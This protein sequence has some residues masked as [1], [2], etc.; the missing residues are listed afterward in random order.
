[1][2]FKVLPAGRKVAWPEAWLKFKF[3]GIFS[4]LFWSMSLRVLYLMTVGWL[5]GIL[6]Y[7]MLVMF[8]NILI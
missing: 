3:E 8:G 2:N 5:F 4:N 1:M 6:F 7:L